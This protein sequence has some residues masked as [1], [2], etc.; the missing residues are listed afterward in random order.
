MKRLTAM[1]VVVVAGSLVAC[2]GPQ[3]TRS[4]EIHTVKIEKEPER[5]ASAAVLLGLAPKHLAT[6]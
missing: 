4:E 1:A 6:G 3:R 5:P 2:A